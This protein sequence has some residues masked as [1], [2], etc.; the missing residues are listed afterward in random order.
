MANPSRPVALFIF[1]FLFGL[2]SARPGAAE[3]PLNLVLENETYFYDLEHSDIDQIDRGFTLI[4][5]LFKPHFRY[6]IKP[7]LTVEAGALLDI[8]FGADDRVEEVEPVISLNYTFLPHWM[9]TAGTIDRDHPLHDAFFDDVL[10]YTEPI[11]QGFQIRGASRHFT[12]DLWISWE[13]RE[14]ANR[15]E[16]FSVGDYTQLKWNGFMIDAQAYWVHLGG[17]LN[18]EPCCFNNLSAGFGGGYTYRPRQRGGI[19][20]E[21]GFTVHYLYNKDIPPDFP[22]ADEDG[23]AARVFAKL[24]DVYFYALAWEGGSQ[25]FNSSQ[26]DA[27]HPG[28]ALAKGDPIYKADNFQ[29]VGFS[30]TWLLA[31]DVTLDVAAR[32]QYIEDKVGAI[33]MV[34]FTWAP[35]IALFEDYFAGRRA[36]SK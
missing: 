3:S 20:D 26:G 33:F 13:I 14:E 8:P 19:L 31:D 22:K 34:S 24:W 17:Q 15:R 1:L 11:E 6:E 18:S 21:L 29:E 7:G 30:K 35:S 2:F 27:T 12:Q 9:V 28:I 5:D 23:I 4:G 25:D 32:G 16:K 10:H 36:I